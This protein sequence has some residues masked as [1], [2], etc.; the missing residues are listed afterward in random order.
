MGEV[1]ALTVELGIDPNRRNATQ[2]LYQELKGRLIGN[3]T[4]G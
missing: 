3:P 2:F 1:R 4:G